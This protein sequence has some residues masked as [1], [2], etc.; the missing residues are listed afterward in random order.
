M[1]LLQYNIIFQEEANS[2]PILFNVSSI[3][4]EGFSFA[5]IG[6][7]NKDIPLLIASSFQS[8]IHL[9]SPQP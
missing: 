2:F 3:S 4:S 6:S 5:I 7:L 9:P 1:I 8:L